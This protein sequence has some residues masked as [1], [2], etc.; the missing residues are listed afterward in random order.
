MEI[1]I[2]MMKDAEAELAIY[3]AKSNQFKP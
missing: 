3:Y 2:G 1:A